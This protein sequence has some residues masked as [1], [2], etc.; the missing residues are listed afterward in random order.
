MQENNQTKC[1][2]KCNIEKLL[3]DFPFDGKYY[4]KTC[5]RCRYLKVK[6]FYDNLAKI[7]ESKRRFYNN[8]EQN[9]YWKLQSKILPLEKTEEN[10]KICW[11]CGLKYHNKLA[12]SQHARQVHKLK[13]K[14]YYD[15]FYK[16][17]GEDNCLNCG[18]K[19][20]LLPSN[21]SY[22]KF[23]SRRC[24]NNYYPLKTQRVTA[25]KEYNLKKHGVEFA[26]QR[27]DVKEKRRQT[28]LKKYGHS[29][30]MFTKEFKE[31]RKQTNLTKYGVENVFSSKDIISKIRKTNIKKYGFPCSSQSEIVKDKF[32]QT[33]LKKYGVEH[34]MQNPELLVKCQ[35]A[36]FRMKS[37]T[38]PSGKI[39]YKQGYEPQFLDYIFNN[40]I[41]KEDEINYSPERIKYVGIDNK[42]HYYFP[43]FYIPKWNL[44]VEIKSCITEKWDKNIEMKKQAVLNKDMAYIKITT[45]KDKLI[46]DEF[47][48]LYKCYM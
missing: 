6:P 7:R 17:D 31:K 26:M 45:I 4:R 39:I 21:D 41:L 11:I 42:E 10:I 47:N 37:Y 3:S 25:C 13:R 35:K 43:D 33:C 15:K 44:I 1:C 36:A 18:N 40:N 5:K 19:T 24:H 28:C 30:N 32:K 14:E 16:K 20:K 12:V 9:H 2:N 8:D 48:K 34:A 38:L 23:C 27:P 46:F 29:S 22:S